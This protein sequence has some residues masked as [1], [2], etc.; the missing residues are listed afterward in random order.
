M[1]R[2]LYLGKYTA[3]GFSGL[4]TEGGSAREAAT[5]QLFEALGGTVRE[6]AFTT[7][8]WD[9]IVLAELPSEAA[10]LAPAIMAS[11]T[12]TVQI[13]VLPLMEPQT[14]DQTSQLLAGIQFRAAGH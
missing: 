11:A 9:F 12:G 5:R 3:E 1:G 4:L 7:G 13:T 10:G 8:T 6:Y 14:V 2:Y